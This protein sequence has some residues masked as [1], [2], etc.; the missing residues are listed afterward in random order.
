MWARGPS[1][2]DRGRSVATMEATPTT[3]TTK[4]V[5]I[6]R[7]VPE[8]AIAGLVEFVNRY[9][10][11]PKMKFIEALSYRKTESGDGFE[12]FWRLKP[13]GPE[14]ARPLPAALRISKAAIELDFPGLDPNDMSLE[15]VVART[16]DEIEAGLFF[17]FHKL[18]KTSHYFFICA[19]E[20]YSEAP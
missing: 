3:E 10:F 17:L 13:V 5:V 9:Y 14:Q 7:D 6:E 19:N 12:L 4:Q 15:S 8:P 11:P 1:R 16:V 2:G 18:K 20:E